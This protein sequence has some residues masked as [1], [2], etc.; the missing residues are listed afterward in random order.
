MVFG[1]AIPPKNTA[2]ILSTVELEGV[3]PDW[4][5]GNSFFGQA[6]YFQQTIVFADGSDFLDAGKLDR[7]DP[8]DAGEL[9]GV[10]DGAKRFFLLATDFLNAMPYRTLCLTSGSVGSAN[11]YSP[12]GELSQ[13]LLSMNATL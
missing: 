2:R 4:G 1:A 13:E 5:Y 11:S 6:H 10:T 7:R 3:F 8:E 9:I 12:K